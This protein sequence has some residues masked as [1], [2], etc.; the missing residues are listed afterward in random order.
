VK[1]PRLR[2]GSAPQVFSPLICVI[3][4]FA[5][6]LIQKAGFTRKTARTGAV[7]L[8]QRFGSALN[9]NL[10]FHM[11]FLDGVYVVGANGEV[12]WFR[13]VRVPT[14]AELTELTHTIAERVGRF[15][16][17]QGLLE[18]DG[19]QSYLAA[20]AVDEG[21][22]DPLLVRSIT[23]R[24]AVGPQAGRKVSLE[25][26][27]HA[28]AGLQSWLVGVEIKS[29]DALKIQLNLVFQQFPQRLFYH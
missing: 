28:T 20:E 15:L 17:R 7:T 16:Q 8:I 3:A 5:S 25:E 13:W 2:P 22:M 11:L 21:T 6:H 14:T 10:H 29:V 27:D 1:I 24:I 26:R 23:Y 12:E 9:L 19:E 4:Q 18:C